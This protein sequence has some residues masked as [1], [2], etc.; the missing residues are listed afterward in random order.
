[1]VARVGGGFPLQA[2]R[3][4]DD[5]VECKCVC[6]CV[7]GGGE[8][9]SVPSRS[10]VS[11]WGTW[12]CVCFL[13]CP[14][15]RCRC[16]GVLL[17]CFGFFALVCERTCVLHSAECVCSAVCE[18]LE[19]TKCIKVGVCYF[20]W[21]QGALCSQSERSS[22]SLGVCSLPLAAF[23]THTHTHAC[24]GLHKQ[25]LIFQLLA[26]FVTVRFVHTHSTYSQLPIPQ[27]QEPHVNRS[28]DTLRLSDPLT[29]TG[30]HW[31]VTLD[32]VN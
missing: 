18:L 20:W 21:C 27:K 19:Y 12:L 3:G 7:S 2:C 11:S 29:N 17:F 1:M 30:Q 15:C 31:D 8:A 4:S 26:N 23:L 6:V 16:V 28:T 14:E 13:C 25:T 24:G 10:W 9:W 32:C 5:K 22:V